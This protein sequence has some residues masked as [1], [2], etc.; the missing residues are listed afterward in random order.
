MK[1]RDEIRI[2]LQRLRGSSR[3]RDL[4]E[5]LTAVSAASGVPVSQKYDLLGR[6]IQGIKPDVLVRVLD[7]LEESG[8]VPEA[9]ASGLSADEPIRC[10]AHDL[11]GHAPLAQRVARELFARMNERPLVLAIVGPWGSGKTSILRMMMEEWQI[12]SSALPDDQRPLVAPFNPWNIS[13]QHQ[14]LTTFFRELS[15]AIRGGGGHPL[16]EAIGAKLEL[17]GRL[18]AP[19]EVALGLL[20]YGHI[21]RPGTWL[22]TIGRRLR[23]SASP[24]ESRREELIRDLEKLRKRIFVILDDIDRLAD[25]EIRQ[26]FQL[27]KLTAGFPYVTYVLAFDVDQVA[28]ALGSVE[29]RPAFLEKLVQVPISVPTPDRN[30]LYSLAF[31]SIVELV[32]ERGGKVDAYQLQVLLSSGTYLFLDTVRAINRLLNSLRVTVPLIVSEV[33]LADFVTLEAL[34]LFAPRTYAALPPLRELF[35]GGGQ[36]FGEKEQ[37]QAQAFLEGLPE[38]ERGVVIPILE[39]LFPR[40]RSHQGAGSWGY[41]DEWTRQLRVCSPRHFDAYFGL[42]RRAGELSESEFQHVTDL[43]RSGVAVDAEIDRLVDHGKDGQFFQRLATDVEDMDASDLELFATPLLTV[44]QRIPSES[45]Q[46][47][48]TDSHLKLLIAAYRILNRIPVESQEAAL[49]RALEAGSIGTV[50]RH[51]RMEGRREEAPHLEVV[52]SAFLERVRD[53]SSQG[54]LA[55]QPHLEHILWAWLEFEGAAG[56][57]AFIQDALG[58]VDSLEKVLPVFS[59]VGFTETAG[60]TSR[61]IRLAVE[62]IEALIEDEERLLDRVQSLDQAVIE[63]MEPRARKVVE[64]IRASRDEIDY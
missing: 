45:R 16:S 2:E 48:D 27:V 10:A 34:R 32:D 13:G 56:P 21:L 24:I 47:W 52:R 49:L 60:R 36:D 19:G 46:M 4:D 58:R 26:I 15:A 40:F 5:R 57:R 64:M 31:R 63:S 43:M 1:N 20:P 53:L 30:T 50:A 25:E 38:K 7:A 55:E 61:H 14:L 44:G 11:L 6:L 62:T 18:I 33:N 12:L 37:R 51:L 54:S 28:E 23:A 41:S 35:V 42:H 39:E 3:L 9:T 29:P 59:S 8:R 22:S 17:Y